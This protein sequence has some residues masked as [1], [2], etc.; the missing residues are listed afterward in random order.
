MAETLA[1]KHADENVV[2]AYRTA[3][4]NAQQLLDSFIKQLEGIEKG[5]SIELPQRITNLESVADSYDGKV[6][7]TMG[8]IKE[9]AEKVFDI[10]SNLDAQQVEE[11]VS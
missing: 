4:N 7:L 8:N 11:Q 10:V 5:H 1:K 2:E 6:N 3:C 9:L